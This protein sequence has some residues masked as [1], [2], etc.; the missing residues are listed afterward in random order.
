MERNE[1]KKQLQLT[2]LN[3]A[4]QLMDDVRTELFRSL[5]TPTRGR[6]WNHLQDQFISRPLKGVTHPED[7][8]VVMIVGNLVK[9]LNE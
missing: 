1:L 5:W 7:Q 3:F 8:F 6:V 2:C 9:D 4:N